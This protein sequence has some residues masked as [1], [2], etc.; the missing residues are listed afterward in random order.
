M[1]HS[2]LSSLMLESPTLISRYD[3]KR[4]L[5]EQFAGKNGSLEAAAAHAAGV[6]LAS[7]YVRTHPSQLWC[8][9]LT[10]PSNWSLSV[11]ASL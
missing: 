11:S 8:T 1:S 7:D 3:P 10:D 2:D 5:Y 6:P 9:A 4:S